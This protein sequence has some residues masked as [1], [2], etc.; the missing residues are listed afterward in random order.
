MTVHRA[1]GLEFPVV[2]PRR[3]DLQRNRGRAASLRRSGAPAVRADGSPAW[4][5][6][7]LLRSRRRGDAPRPG[8]GGAPAVRRGDARARFDRRAG[9]RRRAPAT[10]GSRGSIRRSIPRKR[11]TAH[12][13]RT[14]P[15]GCPEFRAT[16]ASACVRRNA[17]GTSRPA[18]RRDCIVPEAGEHR[19][20]WWDPRMLQARRARDDGPAAD[21]S[22]SKP[23]RAS[24][25]PSRHPR[26][27]SVDQRAR[28]SS[29]RVRG[30]RCS[31]KS[32]TELAAR[33]SSAA[34]RRRW[35]GGRDRSRSS[36]WRDRRDRP[37]GKRFGTLVHAILRASR[38]RCRAR[39]R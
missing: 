30:L 12:A 36:G 33:M 26:I 23:T 21:R 6:A 9:R 16:I 29:R 34:R 7:N 2:H 28:R 11:A 13:A 3:S 15:A 22:C 10:A 35:L 4:R 1:K 27:R 32:A 39:L 38:A 20:V 19:V 25:R 17:S 31:V 18:S 14:R 37:R 8:R 5:R 24:E